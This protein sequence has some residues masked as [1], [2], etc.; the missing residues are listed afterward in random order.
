MGL[1]VG[2]ERRLLGA[3]LPMGARAEP[4][5]DT[6]RPKP[7][8]AL[9]QVCVNQYFWKLVS[10]ADVAGFKLISSLKVE[11][12]FRIGVESFKVN[13]SSTAIA[14]QAWEIPLLLWFI[15]QT[16][17]FAGNGMY[18]L[19]LSVSYWFWFDVAEP[20]LHWTSS[21]NWIVCSK[22]HTIQCLQV[23]NTK[24]YL[25]GPFIAMFS[26]S[27]PYLIEINRMEIKYLIIHIVVLVG[28]ILHV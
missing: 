2:E 11:W 26:V 19:G 27:F 20:E 7:W 21:F 6:N 15:W 12:Y 8:N 22:Q 25:N 1:R 18:Q 23:I 3:R 14:A 5:A 17:I 28:D 16:K 4:H 24:L 9:G 13:P 10:P